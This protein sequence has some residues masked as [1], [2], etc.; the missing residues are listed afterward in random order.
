MIP[1]IIERRATYVTN[2]I[3]HAKNLVKKH[4]KVML[5]GGEMKENTEAIVG[6][7]AILLIQKYHFNKGFFGANGVDARLGYTTPDVREALVKRVAIENTNPGGKYILADHSK[8]GRS[9]NVTFSE[10]GGTTLITDKYP[11][12]E[13]SH[14]A[15][16]KVV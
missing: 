8:F 7:D 3:S 16:L 2:S 12:D 4:F 10:F 14:A 9:A 5:I 13:Y 1:F 11:G 15:N 6:S